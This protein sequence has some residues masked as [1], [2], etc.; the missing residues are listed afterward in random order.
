MRSV[1]VI[2][3]LVCL[4]VILE[5][6]ATNPSPVPTVR[7]NISPLHTQSPVATLPV[8]AA[9]KCAEGCLEPT[10]DCVV[11]GVITGMGDKYYYTPDMPGYKKA[12]VLV[13][14]GARWFCAVDE[15][16]RKGFKKAPP[17]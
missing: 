3:V 16:T 14:Y 13:V 2:L 8:E 12:T 11:K 17:Q 1:Q 15:A 10:S 4:M 7:P 9:S 6:C 5:G